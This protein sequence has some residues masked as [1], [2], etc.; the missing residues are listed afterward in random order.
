M[1]NMI[2][3]LICNI[4]LVALVILSSCSNR[5]G[6][7]NIGPAYEHTEIGNNGGRECGKTSQPR[8]YNIWHRDMPI[9]FSPKKSSDTISVKEKVS[10]HSK[11]DMMHWAGYSALDSDR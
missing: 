11:R 3:C 6:H 8:N 9:R 4:L 10:E 5:N 7:I 1:K 2:Y